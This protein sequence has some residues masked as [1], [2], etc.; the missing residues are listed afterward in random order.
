M[1]AGIFANGAGGG[2]GGGGKESNEA[3]DDRRIKHTKPLA[4]RPERAATAAATE[5]G[6]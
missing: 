2:G 5:A 4:P 1:Q 6:Y 3:S